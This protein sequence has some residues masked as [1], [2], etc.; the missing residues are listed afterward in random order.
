M[1]QYIPDSWVV[2][3]ISDNLHKVLGGFSGGYLYGD[4][5]KLNSG[6]EKIEET[7]KEYL[8]YGFSGS[9][10]VC[11]KGREHL[12]GYTGSILADLQKKV[13]VIEPVEMK[14]VLELYGGISP[15]MKGVDVP[16]GT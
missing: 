10:Y 5:W 12:S 4:S 3:K 7:D 14:A 16:A 8:V 11:R 15:A 6:I 13:P 1:N 2:I 9:V